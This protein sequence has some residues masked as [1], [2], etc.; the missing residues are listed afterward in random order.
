MA[1][2]GQLGVALGEP[3]NV[4]PGFGAAAAAVET[5]GW[6][7]RRPRRSAAQTRPRRRRPAAPLLAAAATAADGLGWMRSRRRTRPPAGGRAPGRRPDAAGIYR[8]NTALMVR[9]ILS[10][11]LWRGGY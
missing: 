3:G 9:N 8:V 7:C 11:G 4:V 10:A 2:T 1:F 5:L 6:L